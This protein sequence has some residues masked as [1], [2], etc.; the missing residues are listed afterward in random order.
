VL[1]DIQMPGWNGYE[2]CTRIMDTQNAWFASMR[3]QLTPVKFKA[4]ACPVVA[5]TA[6]T[7]DSVKVQAKKVGMK[8]VINKPVSHEKLVEILRKYT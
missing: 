4:R 1:T 7:D 3:K 6:F 2:V 5:V 8:E